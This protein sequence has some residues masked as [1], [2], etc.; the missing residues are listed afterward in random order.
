MG[1]FAIFISSKTEEF[2]NT[3]KIL[4]KELEDYFKNNIKIFIFESDAGARNEASDE[5]Y[6]NEIINSNIYIGLFKNEYSKPT[7]KEYNL[8]LD[9]NKHILI[10]INNTN[11]KERQGELNNLIKEIQ[12]RHTYDTFEND[13]ELIEKIKNQIIR[14]LTERFSLQNFNNILPNFEFINPT[15]FITHTN[16]NVNEW[17][18][19][20]SMNLV[21]IKKKKHFTRDNILINILQK[22]NQKNFLILIGQSG[23]SKSIVLNEILCHYHESHFLVFKLDGKQLISYPVEI[24]K[25]LEYLMSLKKKIFIAIDNAHSVNSIALYYIIDE[26]QSHQ[27]S[28]YIKFVLTAKQPEFD[29][30]RKIENIQIPSNIPESHINSFYKLANQKLVHYELPPFTRRETKLFISKYKNRI[31]FKSQKEIEQHFNSVYKETKGCPILVFYSVFTQGFSKYVRLMKN[32]YLN[33]EDTIITMIICSILSL[34]ELEITE[35]T[36]KEMNIIELAYKL[37]KITLSHSSNFKW[38]TIHP[39][40]DEEFLSLLLKEKEQY[41]T[42]IKYFYEAIKKIFSMKNSNI[43]YKVILYF[44]KMVNNEILPLNE[45]EKIDIP[46]YIPPLQKSD[47]LVFL[48]LVYYSRGFNKGGPQLK[49]YWNISLT[50]YDEAIKL[51]KNN[52]NAYEAKGNSYHQLEK[53]EEAIYQYEE[54][55]RI[56]PSLGKYANIINSLRRMKYYNRAQELIEEVG[57]LKKTANKEE[58]KVFYNNNGLIYMDKYFLYH[59]SIDLTIAENYFHESNNI[60]LNVAAYANLGILEFFFYRDYEKAL[61]YF[62]NAY[63]LDSYFTPAID[64]IIDCLMILGKEFEAKKYFKILKRLNIKSYNILKKFYRKKDGQGTR[65]LA[66]PGRGPPHHRPAHRRPASR[67][68]GAGG[69][70]GAGGAVDRPS[71]QRLGAAPL[72]RVAVPGPGRLPRRWRADLPRPL[73]PPG[74]HMTEASRTPSM[75]ERASRPS[76]V[77]RRSGPQR[78]DRPA[79]WAGRLPGCRRLPGIMPALCL[80]GTWPCCQH[81][82]AVHT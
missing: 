2:R 40:W 54:S 23:Y 3:R 4:K 21:S 39:K 58:L 14:V 74:P 31:E 67:Q 9:Y 30:M 15:Y 64:F 16:E 29:R 52:Y 20:F 76:S 79:P 70:A 80:F 56:R 25:N 5:V 72:A 61:H 38:N 69:A 32:E 18:K 8:A 13:N 17:K 28:E 6:S 12:E 75:R 22:L 11:I 82:P 59:N 57:Y 81:D 49:N 78:V 71:R 66:C 42:N 65:A 44:F 60:E 51:H 50:K 77:R 73:A 46:N 37:D 33:S 26:I 24:M 62:K 63:E 55:I 41:F 53:F 48:G 36:L 27:N 68:P 47:L 45:L 43:G 35:N 7:E 10:Y 1:T 34:A 19:G